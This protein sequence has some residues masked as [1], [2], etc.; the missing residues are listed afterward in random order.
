MCLLQRCLTSNAS[1]A[2]VPGYLGGF[3]WH[4]QCDWVLSRAHGKLAILYLLR[5]P[6]IFVWTLD[7]LQPLRLYL[8][9]SA[10]PPASCNDVQEVTS[11]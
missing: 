4:A 10:V 1:T 3:H 6:M 7:G 8:R 2:W 11:A 9:L 5:H